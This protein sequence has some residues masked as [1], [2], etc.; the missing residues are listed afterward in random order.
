[1]PPAAGFPKAATVPISISGITLPVCDALLSFE[2][3]VMSSTFF[4]E[5]GTATHGPNILQPGP[6]T[7]APPTSTSTSTGQ[8]TDLQLSFNHPYRLKQLSTLEIR[9]PP[10]MAL[11]PASLCTLTGLEPG[12]TCTQVNATTL[13]VSSGM[14]GADRPAGGPA[15]AVSVTGVK[16]PTTIGSF[17]IHVDVLSAEGCKYLTGTSTLTID[18]LPAAA[19]ASFQPARPLKNIFS[20]Y[21]FRFAPSLPVIINPGDYLQ[22]HFPPSMALSSTPQCSPLSPNL[23]AATCTSPAPQRLDI[24]ITHSQPAFNTDQL[25]VVELRY[26]L[27]P[28]VDGNSQPLDMF[29]K[30]ALGNAYQEKRALVYA[31]AGSSQISSATA[32]FES[33]FKGKEDTT[34]FSLKLD[35]YLNRGSIISIKL[36]PDFELQTDPSVQ[37]SSVP[38]RIDSVDRANNLVKLYLDGPLEPNTDLS[39]KLALRNPVVPTMPSN[40]VAVSVANPLSIVVASATPFTS[41]QFFE[42]HASCLGCGKTYT[43]CLACKDGYFLQADSSCAL[44]RTSQTARSIGFVFL[45]IALLMVLLVLIYGL[46]C[47]RR[48]FNFNCLYALLRI[49]LTI[50][51]IILFI[52]S[53]LSTLPG[54]YIGVFAA[55]LALHFLLSILTAR[56]TS[57]M[58]YHF[59]DHT[60]SLKSAPSSP[61]PRLALLRVAHRCSYFFSLSVLRYCYSNKAAFKGLFWEFSLDKFDKLKRILFVVGIVY[62]LLVLCPISILSLIYYLSSEKILYMLE[63]PLLALLDVL[64][65]TGACIELYRST[66]YHACFPFASDP[67]LTH[68]EPMLTPSAPMDEQGDKSGLLDQTM[69]KHSVAEAINSLK[70]I[71]KGEDGLLRDGDNRVVAEEEYRRLEEVARLEGQVRGVVRGKD[72]VLRDGDRVVAEEDYRRLVD[73][74]RRLLQGGVEER[75]PEDGGNRHTAKK[76]YMESG[77]KRKERERAREE[78][79][80]VVRGKDGVLRNGE[81]QVISEE[82]YQRMK[83]E[84]ERWVDS[85]IKKSKEG[86]WRE[87]DSGVNSEGEYTKNRDRSGRKNFN[88]DLPHGSDDSNILYT[89]KSTDQNAG[90]FPKPVPGGPNNNQPPWRTVSGTV[91]NTSGVGRPEEEFNRKGKDG[92]ERS[93]IGQGKDGQAKD[94]SGNQGNQANRANQG[95]G[96]DDREMM[97]DPGMAGKQGQMDRPGQMRMEGGPLADLGP[98]G[99]D[100]EYS[101]PR[102]QMLSMNPEEREELREFERLERL[103]KVPPMTGIER[104]IRELP[105]NYQYSQADKMYKAVN[106]KPLK[107]S[108]VFVQNREKDKLIE[109]STTNS[110]PRGNQPFTDDSKEV[111]FGSSKIDL[112]AGCELRPAVPSRFLE[113]MIMDKWM[114]SC[115]KNYLEIIYEE[116]EE[117]PTPRLQERLQYEHPDLEQDMQRSKLILG[118]SQEV[119][120]LRKSNVAEAVLSN[121]PTETKN[122]LIAEL[123]A[124]HSKGELN[125]KE[126]SEEINK[127]KRGNVGL[128]RK[129][130]SERDAIVVSKEGDLREINGQA[131]E[132]VKMGVLSDRN[133]NKLRLGEQKVELLQQ[134]VLEDEDGHRIQMNSQDPEELRKGVITDVEGRKYRL[135]DQSFQDLE[136]G[137]FYAPDGQV[138]NINGQSPEDINQGILVD[139][140][141]KRLKVIKQTRKE[142]EK[143]ILKTDD[144]LVLRLPPGQVMADIQ[145]G[146]FKGPDGQ[147]YRIKDQH[148]ERMGNDLIYRNRDL[149]LVNGDGSYL[150]PN[151]PRIIGGESFFRASQERAGKGYNPENPMHV[152][153]EEQRRA[154]GGLEGPGKSGLPMSKM[155]AAM[156][157]YQEVNGFKKDVILQN[158][159]DMENSLLNR[160]LN[161]SGSLDRSR[162]GLEY[163]K[164]GKYDDG[165][166]KHTILKS[167]TQGS[168]DRQSPGKYPLKMRIDPETLIVNLIAE[169]DESFDLAL[170]IEEA[171]EGQSERVSVRMEDMQPG[172]GPLRGSKVV[173][174]DYN[175]GVETPRSRMAKVGASKLTGA[176]HLPV[177]PMYSGGRGGFSIV[178]GRPK[179][180][181]I[182]SHGNKSPPPGLDRQGGKRPPTS[183]S[184]EGFM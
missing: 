97:R 29:L 61:D 112:E 40:A 76:L 17:P 180:D 163:R 7:L 52:L 55:T 126:L 48:N 159:E 36:S 74:Q 96:K 107:P 67:K 82:R 21:T 84:N 77:E 108:N 152:Y 62:I 184:T 172:P 144:G 37:S 47:K 38:M 23:L 120:K 85:T 156:Q 54:Y 130:L 147:K 24:A 181:G 26:A 9:L 93:V 98:G 34:N 171:E 179:Q 173:I 165:G 5:K 145:M 124:K 11:Q 111:Q 43:Q 161:H 13:R 174:N 102:L 73:Q 175:S 6:L 68:R 27:N 83:E 51:L 155:E 103:G 20:T 131:I 116:G 143:G 60:L 92:M 30:D 35:S 104:K 10:T 78:L 33:K 49:N 137:I 53:L 72:G 41:D 79:Q 70:G 65:F 164:L 59:A 91:K 135:A 169:N 12:A 133:N 63:L 28:N 134:G 88:I 58:A 16:N 75:D 166:S 154:E 39:F 177:Q 170:N 125:S 106:P 122:R 66:A 64:I 80:A 146:L 42:C 14:A 157:F 18:T 127:M 123:I 46:L 25:F 50:G 45:G 71:K 118:N 167:I 168:V 90:L 100:T 183:N 4:V 81:N 132:N 141:G 114:F 99:N 15:I 160:D 117:N 95:N 138:A 136:K 113:N 87:L 128:F 86:G 89:E 182:M 57:N 69:A 158:Q 121:L 56:L 2:V 19:L 22:V 110:K 176:G 162:G 178:Q 1:M 119:E 150:V 140:T 115:S 3:Q 153:R 8:P 148:F 31:Y 139:G 32:A 94:G 44:S 142:L 101:D 151:D 149:E 105:T 109:L 129:L